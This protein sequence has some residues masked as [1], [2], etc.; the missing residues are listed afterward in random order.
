MANPPRVFLSY[1]HDSLTH[2][3]WIRKLATDLRNNGV[4]AVLDQWDLSPGE[5][6]ATFME[7]GLKNADRVVVISS[8][9]YVERAN[10]GKG[11]VGYEKMIVTAELIDNLGTKKFIPIIRN[12]GSPPVPIFLGYRLYIDFEA[13]EKYA[14][15]LETLLREIHNISDPGKP[16]IG[17][18]PFDENGQSKIIMST[19]DTSL[20]VS[21]SKS[22]QELLSEEPEEDTEQL[23]TFLKKVISEPSHALK[24][25][26]LIYPITTQARN[27]LDNSAIEEYSSMPTQ[28]EFLRRIEIGNKATNK[29]SRLFAVACH[30]ATPEQAKT[31][32]KSLA[33]LALVPKPEGT[34]YDIWLNVAHYPALRLL[35]SGAI[36]AFTNDSYSVLREMMLNT[37]SRTRPNEPETSLL[38][39]LH[40]DAGFAQNHWKWLPRRERHYV[41]LSDYLEESLRPYFTELI[42]DEEEFSSIFDRYEFFQALLYGDL[43]GDSDTWGFWTPLGSFIWRR[44]NLFKDVHE[45]I[46][47]QGKSWKPI[48]AGFFSGSPDRAIEV[49][50]K[51]QD[52][53]NRVR[54]QMGIW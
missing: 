5:D 3:Q 10:A 51:L 50:Q 38:V 29:L 2:K 12:A 26:D 17:K 15:S 32:S 41:P 33:R 47:V 19:M 1:S 16:P 13:D 6:I 31:L 14:T 23:V 35:Y 44:R 53:T 43:K 48:E 37:K 22:T 49:L 34:F 25:H 52:F 8:E 28:E 40:S 46:K 11:G 39:S 18:N 54:Q 7:Q 36:G 4:D 21:P 9:K 45:E 24:L 30:W 20:S 42:N 27:T